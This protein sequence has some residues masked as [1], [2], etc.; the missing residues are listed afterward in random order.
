MRRGLS[1]RRFAELAGYTPSWLSKIKNGTPPSVDFARRCDELLEARGALLALAGT[2]RPRPAELPAAVAGFVGR[3]EHLAHLDALLAKPRPPGA[4][5]LAV[6]EGAPGVG[7]TALA[8]RWAHDASAR[9]PD[10]QLYVDLRGFAH[11]RTPTAPEDVLEELLLALGASTTDIGPL[12]LARRSALLRSMLADRQVLLVLDNAASAEQVQPLLPGSGSCF[13]VVTSR[14]AMSALAVRTHGERLDVGR[15]TDEEGE[16]LV[17]EA[18]GAARLADAPSAPTALT[19]LVQRCGHL[20]LALRIA[21][22]HLIT[23]PLLSVRD[24]V[25]QLTEED[26]RLDALALDDRVAVRTVFS[27]SYRGL[28]DEERRVLRLIS[29]LG[30]AETTTAAIAAVAGVEY[31]RAQQLLHSLVCAH[32]LESRGGDRYRLHELLR[33]YAAERVAHEDD[34]EQLAA[35]LARFD[36][37]YC[38]DPLLMCG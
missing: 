3:R 37:R 29:A 30:C 9:F 4:S 34:P 22:E 7:K 6:I 10:G 25:D 15:L 38:P 21:A 32:M 13:V 33:L 31:E 28:D 20:P 19:E 16:E 35:A 12:S 14:R 27:W 23:D 11:C 24:L 26:H 2:S 36:H 1:W 8:L 17:R 18:V 5:R